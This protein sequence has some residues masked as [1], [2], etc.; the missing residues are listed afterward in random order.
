MES[1]HTSKF[2]FIFLPAVAGI[3]LHLGGCAAVHKNTKAE[4]DAVARCIRET[5]LSI[6]ECQDV[7]DTAAGR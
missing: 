1:S 5:G 2:R 6:Y 3:L 7:V 4:D